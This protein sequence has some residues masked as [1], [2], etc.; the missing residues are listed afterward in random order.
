MAKKQKEMFEKPVK[1]T[2]AYTRAVS[3]RKAAIVFLAPVLLFLTVFMVYPIVDT[4]VTSGY[5]WNGISADRQ[6]LGIFKAGSNWDE[7]IHDDNFWHAFRNNLIVMVLS[8]LLQMPIGMLLATFLDAGGKKLNFFK[9]VW[10][11]PYLM[12]STAIAFLF[13]YALATNDG[14][15]TAAATLLRGK[16]TAID[17]LGRS[18][19]ALF[20]VIGV[21]AW[22]FAPFYMVYFIAGY[23]GIDETLYEA[24]IIDG[25]TRGKYVR[26]VALPLLKPTIKAACTMSLI[27]SLKYF[28]LIWNMTQG[29]PGV[30]SELMATYMYKQS[31]K[32]F[33]MGYGSAVAGG[34]FIL[35][36]LI[37]L[38]FNRIF[39]NKED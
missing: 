38:L 37:A 6:W 20:T 1:G 17:L 27:G 10:F 16:R 3:T 14:L 35:I 5:R 13:T 30:T 24:A 12:S 31:F 34:M 39:Q 9:T 29:G 19:H 4:F 8:I 36:T 15:I 11:F 2:L 28:D 32:N 23:S 33:K 7:L 25:A 21:M 22:Q 26:Y 18:P